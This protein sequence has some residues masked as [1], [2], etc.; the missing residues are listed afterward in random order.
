MNENTVLVWLLVLGTGLYGAIF[1]IPFTYIERRY[2]TTHMRDVFFAALVWV[3]IEYIRSQYVLIG[4]GW[5]TIGYTLV[6]ATMLRGNALIVGVYGLSFLIVTMNMF[7]T[8]M[9][10][11]L[12]DMPFRQY[13]SQVR[14]LFLSRDERYWTISFVILWFIAIVNG[15]FGHAFITAQASGDT[16]LHVATVVAGTAKNPTSGELYFEYRT[17]LMTL[18]KTHQ[19]TELVLL[20]ENVFPF[21]VVEEETQKLFDAQIV[22]ME[23]REEYYNNFLVLTA[24]HPN[25]V[26]AVGLHTVSSGELYNSLVFYKNRVIIDVLHKQKLVP[27]FEYAPLGLP[28]PLY[29]S[30]SH[31]R[32]GQVIDF[33]GRT[34]GMLMCSEISDGGILSDEK[35]TIIL[36]PSNDA[37]F[38]GTT[39]G[40]FHDTFARM[41][42][43][44]SGAY[45]L[46]ANKG[47][48]SSVIDPSGNVL[49][50][51][52]GDAIIFQTIN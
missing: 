3:V 19:N 35:I 47:S 23:K 49:S 4:Y 38:S 52:Y 22:P 30:L 32:E 16:P 25:A 46:R 31:G 36:S 20:P 14:T 43:I 2:R 1:F 33:S 44:E 24:L 18:F 8:L 12:H 27:F 13:I 17:Q 11:R 29:E 41:R 45:V 15:I 21:F 50:S 37:I 40:R 39:A 26:F 51:G 48:F 34:L 28:I 42:A 7:I 10:E 9:Y 6:D 5:G